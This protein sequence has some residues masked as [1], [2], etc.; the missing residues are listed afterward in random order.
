M[1]RMPINQLTYPLSVLVKAVEFKNLSSASLHVGLSQPQLSRMIAKLEEELGV[2]LLNRQVKRKSSW[3][4]RA[5]QLAHLFER[6]QR[7]L[8]HAIHALQS[9]QVVRQIHIGTLEGLTDLA[10]TLSRRLFEKLGLETVTLDVF[11]RAELEARFLSGDLD[12]IL[13]TRTVSRGKPKYQHVCAFQALEHVERPGDFQLYS[14]FEQSQRA[15]K[16][17]ATT[18]DHSG[19]PSATPTIVSNSLYVRKTWL[20]RYGGKSSMPSS[21]TD[22]PKRGSDEILL[23]GGEWLDPR[24]WTVLC[25]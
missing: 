16:K 23:L 14:T 15:R 12:V 8:D 1:M 25:E 17:A 7:R 5:A 13:N 20:D 3:T 21:T 10:V 19:R 2:E 22:K 4:P 11:D 18:R 6:H 24:V 9:S